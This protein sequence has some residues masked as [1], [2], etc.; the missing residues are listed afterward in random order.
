M[1]NSAEKENRLLEDSGEKNGFSF[2][3]KTGEK[4]TKKVSFF[5][6]PKIAVEHRN[7]A[8]I[9]GNSKSPVYERR[10][11]RTDGRINERQGLKTQK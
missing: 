7:N 5:S 4:Q 8:A 6:T 1:E 9:T 2:G 11:T 10:N 3:Q